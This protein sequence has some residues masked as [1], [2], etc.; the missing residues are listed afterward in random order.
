MVRLTFLY[1]NRGLT[2]GLMAGIFVALLIFAR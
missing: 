2:Q 1:G